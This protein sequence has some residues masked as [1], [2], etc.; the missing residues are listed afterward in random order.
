MGIYIKK[1]S[2]CEKSILDL[3]TN[4]PK[5]I[6]WLDLLD[7][8]PEEE[9]KLEKEL[10]IDIPTF[11][12]T[13]GLAIS[14][15]LYENNKAT[16]ATISL[17]LNNHVDITNLESHTITF[18]IRNHLLITI[19]NSLSEFFDIKSSTINS[20]YKL[21]NKYSLRIFLLL[22]E[23]FINNTAALL[24]KIIYHLNDQTEKL[25]KNKNTSK[26]RYTD[27]LSDLANAGNS[28]TLIQESLT[29][30][31]RMIDFLHKT[32]NFIKSN[33]TFLNYI[34]AFASDLK[35]LNDQTSF[36]SSKVS[37]LLDATLGLIN[38]EQ[39]NIIKFFSIISVIF[40]PPM[41]IASIYGM[42]FYIIPELKWKFG[43]SWA[44]ILM[45][46]SAYLPYRYIKKKGW[47]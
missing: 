5:D 40:T 18:I 8:S 23:S 29:S 38:I 19:R 6:L 33:D 22:I 36:L 21:V 11:E 12:E 46:F 13:K 28:I 7:I 20:K 4:L 30:F 2:T 27:L 42:N 24:E 3:H 16:Y 1:K 17:Y 37:F 26:I 32:D 41:L 43:Y 34:S 44:I 15:R 47:F 25:T 35:S 10:N 45:I 39:N 14:N 9:L 31:I